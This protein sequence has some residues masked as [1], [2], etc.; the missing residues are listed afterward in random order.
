MSPDFALDLDLATGYH[1]ATNFREGL[2]PKKSSE[3][4]FRQTRTKVSIPE[5]VGLLASVNG[6]LLR[7]EVAIKAIYQNPLKE[8]NTAS[9]TMHND[10]HSVRF[11]KNLEK[12]FSCGYTNVNEKI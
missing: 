8:S 9:D 10:A 3:L 12:Q 2:R 6:C 11:F 7:N 4:L 5:Q 1:T